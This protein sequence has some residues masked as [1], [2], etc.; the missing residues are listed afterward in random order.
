MKKTIGIIGGMGPMA[1]I[2][3]YRKIIEVTPANS[4][5]DHIHVVIDSNTLI[6]D[7]TA[8]ILGKGEDPAMEMIRTAISLENMGADFL[9]MACNTA[10]YYY[11][12]IIPFIKIPMLNMIDETVKEIAKLKM[13]TV[14]LLATDG[15]LASKVYEYKLNEY[16]INI[17]KPSEE[18]QK[19]V[20]DLIYNGIKASDFSLD[21]SRFRT[22]IEELYFSGAE[23]LILGCTELPIA[24]E[25]FSLK[26]NAIDPTKILAEKAVQFAFNNKNN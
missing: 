12:R 13:N 7:R 6:P 1:T 22:V 26:G 14:G 2:D 4:D 11:D 17:I 16:E 5:N 3:L 25:R 24:F 10:Y 8:Y 23:T 21:I 18:G 15:V 9:I 19:V 20:M